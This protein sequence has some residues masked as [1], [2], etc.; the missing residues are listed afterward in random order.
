MAL[1]FGITNGAQ[2]TKVSKQSASRVADF[3]ETNERKF[4]KK[5]KLSKLRMTHRSQRE[6]IMVAVP[7]SVL[8][9]TV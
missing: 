6:V 9:L 7:S 1:Q 4:K 2:H 5:K 8:V 3:F